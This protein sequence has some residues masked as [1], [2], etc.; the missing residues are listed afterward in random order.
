MENTKEKI[1]SILINTEESVRKVIVKS[2]ENGDYRGVDT[3]R[4][5]AVKI[6]ELKMQL[7]ESSASP[8]I[9]KEAVT[10]IRKAQRVKKKSKRRKGGKSGYPK[11]EVRNGTLIRIGWSKKQ[12]GEYTHKVPK[13]VF[14]VTVKAMARLAKSGAGPF[15][16]EEIIDRVNELSADAVPSYQVYVVVGLLRKVGCIKQVGREGYGIP[17][18]VA[19]KAQDVWGKITAK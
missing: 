1:K 10:K 13:V 3:A 9:T 12:K 14:D 16:A 15:M 5:I 17:V 11:F 6:Y 2:A 19:E 18:D 4:M 7:E 8:I